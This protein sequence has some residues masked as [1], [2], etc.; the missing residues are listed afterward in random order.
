[1]P[2]LSDE[3]CPLFFIKVP[4][5]YLW[6]RSVLILFKASLSKKD[7]ND[8]STGAGFISQIPFRFPL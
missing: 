5:V 1:M 2:L 8:L 3:F 4:A 6:L 7:T